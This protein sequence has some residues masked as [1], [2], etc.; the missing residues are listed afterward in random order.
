M[1]SQDNVYFGHRKCYILRLPVE[2]QTQI[3]MEC[4]PQPFG[5]LMDQYQAPHVLLSVCKG[6]RDIV[7]ATSSLWSS[8]EAQFGTWTLNFKDPEGDAVLLSRMKLWLRRSGNYPLSVKLLYEL[9]V[10][11]PRDKILSRFPSEALTLL[12]QHS[13]RWR[14]IELSIPSPCLVPLLKQTSELHLPALDSLV[15]T[16]LPA[17]TFRSE[18]LD[19]RTLV[20]NCGQLTKLNVNLAAGQALNL[21]DCATILSQNPHLT[22]CT[23]YAQCTFSGSSAAERLILPALTEFHLLVFSNDGSLPESLHETA[24]TSFLGGLE[25]YALKSL[26]IEWFLNTSQRGWSSSHPGFVSF[27][28][29]LNPKLET[30]RLGYLPLSE[31]QVIDYM[32]ALPSLTSVELLF[33][34]GEDSEG[35]AITDSFWKA[36]TL[37]DRTQG[38][39]NQDYASGTLLPRVQSM[40]IQCHGSG[41][42]DRELVRFIDSRAD[43]ELQEAQFE[44]RFRSLKLRTQVPV[45]RA[46]N[47]NREISDWYG[48]GIEIQAL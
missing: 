33:G 9:P 46:E 47:M 13:A 41:C 40:N 6:W 12:M 18:P 19:L 42:S 48:K 30:L 27:L 44:F 16:P 21:D 3:F 24:L 4:L 10:P 37:S 31:E 2:L 34:L 43:P 32:K 23:L 26:H 28:E 8:F 22:S 38:G 45:L 20:S 36:L 39:Y 7:Y 11:L 17:S 1:N 5:Q 35:P 14:H 29:S 15:L 25:L